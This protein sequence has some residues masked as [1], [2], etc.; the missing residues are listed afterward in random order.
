MIDA[1]PGR[2]QR[3]RRIHRRALEF[4]F[5]RGALPLAMR[6]TRRPTRSQ[7]TRLSQRHVSRGHPSRSPF[8]SRVLDLHPRGTGRTCSGSP[9]FET[10]PSRPMRQAWRNIPSPSFAVQVLAVDDRGAGALQ[11]LPEQ[12]PALDEGKPT[13]IL[14]FTT[15]GRTR[16]GTLSRSQSGLGARGSPASLRAMR[17]RLAVQDDP[18]ERRAITAAGSRRSRLPNSARSRLHSRTSSPSF[19]ATIGSH[20]ASP[21]AAIRRRPAP[22]SRARADRPD[23]AGRLA[24]IPGESRTHQHRADVITRNIES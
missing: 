11:V 7:R 22:S 6:P 17:D 16:R 10:I 3:S 9:R 15:A 5:G 1:R 23:E 12:G 2:Q 4:R 8:I 13:Q 21:R 18:G 14:V 20:R 24:P 19:S